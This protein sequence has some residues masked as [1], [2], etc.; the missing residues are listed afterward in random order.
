[1]EYRKKKVEQDLKTKNDERIKK[2]IEVKIANKR[3]EQ[4][5]TEIQEELKNVKYY[6]K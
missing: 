4:R 6:G 3:K 2:E 5:L 1:M